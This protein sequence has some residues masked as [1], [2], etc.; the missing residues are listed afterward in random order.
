LLLLEYQRSK[1]RKVKEYSRIILVLLAIV[2]VIH[3]LNVLLGVVLG[4]LPVDEIHALGLGQLVNLGTGET[5][6]HLLGKLMGDG[7]A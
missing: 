5:D 1:I 3:V 7:L 2:L 4:L 6:K